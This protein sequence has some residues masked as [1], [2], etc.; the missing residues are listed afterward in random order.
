MNKDELK[1]MFLE[2]LWMRNQIESNNIS[3]DIFNFWIDVMQKRD[4][5][6]VEDLKGEK[7][8]YNLTDT[9]PHRRGKEAYNRG[10][11]KA[12]DIINKK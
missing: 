10:I 4:E 11:T 6:L 3:N 9:K 1:K 8:V 5:E 7:M 2:W 12:I